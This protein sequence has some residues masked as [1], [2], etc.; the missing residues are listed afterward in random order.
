MAQSFRDLKVWN[1]A[2]DLTVL[3]YQFT[4]DFPKQEVYGLTSQMRRASV[5]VASNIAEG[6]ARGTKKDFRQFV[7]LAH[8]SNCELQTQLVISRRLHFGDDDRCEAIENLSQEVGKMLSGLNEYL[9]DQIK[10]HSLTT[11]N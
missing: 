8:G 3:I 2:I 1:K 4:A 11:E 6:S 9:T 10:L 7:K 5:S